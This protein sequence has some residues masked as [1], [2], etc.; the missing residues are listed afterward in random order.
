MGGYVPEGLAQLQRR[1]V[2]ERQG[3]QPL[4]GSGSADVVHAC[5]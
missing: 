3:Y 2:L 5:A 1:G 4:Y